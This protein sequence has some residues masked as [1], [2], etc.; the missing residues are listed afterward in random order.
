MAG[1]NIALLR[2][3]TRP[4]LTS[5]KPMMTVATV[6]VRPTRAPPV[7]AVRAT[8][9]LT[10]TSTMESSTMGMEMICTEQNN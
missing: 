2:R 5:F 8:V 3:Q 10:G 4:P 1:L 6:S 9:K 7:E